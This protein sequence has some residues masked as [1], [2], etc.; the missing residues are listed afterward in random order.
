MITSVYTVHT[1]TFIRFLF[2][3]ANSSDLEINDSAELIST[4]LSRG[5]S[6]AAREYLQ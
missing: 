5:L 1:R 3:R 2:A 6:V 4:K